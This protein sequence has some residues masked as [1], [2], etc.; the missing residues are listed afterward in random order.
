MGQNKFRAPPDLET[1]VFYLFFPTT[2][3]TKSIIVPFKNWVINIVREGNFPLQICDGLY[4]CKYV[5][6]HI[7][8]EGVKYAIT[9]PHF[10]VGDTLY[11][12]D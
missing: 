8:S 10:K 4:L 12:M 11:F 9:P 6:T 5:T 7:C 2:E 3:W 1:L